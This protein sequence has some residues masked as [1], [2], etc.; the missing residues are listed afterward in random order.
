MILHNLMIENLQGSSET[1]DGSDWTKTGSNRARNGLKTASKLIL[2]SWVRIGTESRLSQLGF[3][4]L[5][6]SGWLG[7]EPLARV[8]SGLSR[9]L[10]WN[11]NVSV[12]FGQLF[13]K[14]C[15]T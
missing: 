4:Q 3:A 15:K 12:D 11:D 8:G 7:S 13:V 9:R 14:S 2:L 6:G 5:V 10:G 1:V